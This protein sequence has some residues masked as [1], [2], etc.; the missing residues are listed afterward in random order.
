MSMGFRRELEVA[1]MRRRALAA[2][3]DLLSLLT[4]F[5]GWVAGRVWRSRHG[6][7]D[8]DSD[9]SD[10]ASRLRRWVQFARSSSG[11]LAL[12]FASLTFV[13][14]P[15]RNGQSPGMRAA[16]IQMVDARSGGP[17]SIRSDLNVGT[18]LGDARPLS[19]EGTAAARA[20]K[21]DPSAPPRAP[22]AAAVPNVTWWPPSCY[23]TV[24]E[25]MKRWMASLALS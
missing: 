7:T 25:G 23:A 9:R 12:W 22:C 14:I 4:I 17:V 24:F 10:R 6:I 11:Q 5:A 21:Q 3:L 8:V 2:A 13:A 20:S 16:G 19:P 18:E 15:F 1:S